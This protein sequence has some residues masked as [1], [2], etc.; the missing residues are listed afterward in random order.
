MSS[1]SIISKFEKQINELRSEY[2]ERIPEKISEIESEW[3]DFKT[4]NKKWDGITPLYFLT[5]KLTGLTASFQLNEVHETANILESYLQYLI[6]NKSSLNDIHFSKI[7]DLITELK[8]RAVTCL[9]QNAESEKQDERFLKQFSPSSSPKKLIYILESDQGLSEDL[10]HQIAFFGYNVQN[11]SDFNSLRNE[12]IISSP[13]AI[14]FD[15]TSRPKSIDSGKILE[16]KNL[17]EIPIPII[18]ISAYAEL[19]DRLHSV[20][21]G[22]DAYFNNPVDITKLIDK[23]DSL[24]VRPAPD[25]FRIMVID[26]EIFQAAYNSLL[27]QQAGMISAVVSDP[28][29]VMETLI[30]FRPELILMAMY[31]KECS[32]MELASVIRQQDAYIGVPIVFLATDANRNKEMEVMRQGGDDFLTK[33]ILPEDLISSIILRAERS[34]ILGSFMQRDSLTGLFNHT[35]IKEQ[36]MIELTRT[37]RQGGNLAFAM[38]DIDS[39][40]SVN[41]TYGHLTG[42]RVIKNLSRLLMQRLRK[43]DIIG[44]YGGEEFAIIFTDTKVN[45]A[46]KVLDE[47]RKSFASIHQQ[48]EGISFSASFSFGICGYPETDGA[49]KINEIA[50]RA[51]YEAKRSGRNRG[52]LSSK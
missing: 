26:D 30:D 5:H 43:T 37:K 46:F 13:S 12:S 22:S 25:P 42:D 14:I 48:S 29:R 2:R 52:V 51:L 19:T 32:G 49:G 7:D 9:N 31:M 39:F 23:L 45:N 11:F 38:L 28:L 15:I 24:T 18:F 27:L 33:S 40:K 17:H 35:K 50:D 47:I 44:R 16:L 34:R 8:S 1:E 4:G 20:R 10:N 6:E 21:A 41:D 3:N 36:L